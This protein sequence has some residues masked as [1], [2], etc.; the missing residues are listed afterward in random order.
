MDG[1]TNQSR[2]YTIASNP[3]QIPPPIKPLDMERQQLR[4]PELGEVEFENE[5]PT[6]NQEAR[7]KK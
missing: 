1:I 5:Q 7:A 2:H 3:E 4:L 6:C